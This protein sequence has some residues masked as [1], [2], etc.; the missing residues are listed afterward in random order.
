MQYDADTLRVLP[1]PCRNSF[2]V[3]HLVKGQR[4]HI[5]QT[6]IPYSVKTTMNIYFLR[7]EPTTCPLNKKINPYTSLRKYYINKYSHF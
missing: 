6:I 5:P 1:R 7:A 4:M 3:K 2:E